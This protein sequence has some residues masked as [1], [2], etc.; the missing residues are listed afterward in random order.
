MQLLAW[1]C[2]EAGEGPVSGTRVTGRPTLYQVSLDVRR[3]MTAF[4]HAREDGQPTGTG[5]L[6]AA[7]E[8]FLWLAGWS[9]LPPVDR[10]GHGTFE[11]CPERETPCRCGEA[12]VCLRRR[13]PACW[14]V[15][16]ADDNAGSFPAADVGGG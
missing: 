14:R 4:L 11:D 12:G 10:H 1:V 2:G 5:R 13:C 16:C 6:E 3:A 9:P 7:M 15:S 8:G